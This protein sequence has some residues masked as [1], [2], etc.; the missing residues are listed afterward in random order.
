VL[1][2]INLPPTGVAIIIVEPGGPFTVTGVRFPPG[3]ALTVVFD[4]PAVTLAT[5]TADGA[6]N[7]AVQVTAPATAAPGVHQVTTTGGGVSLTQPVYVIP[8]AVR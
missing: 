7:F 2:D 1:I 3:A 8:P 5:P 4:N 6:G